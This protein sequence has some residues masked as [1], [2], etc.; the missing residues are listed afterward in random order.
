MHKTLDDLVT[1][2]FVLTGAIDA[3]KH[4]LGD[5]MDAQTVLLISKMEKSALELFDIIEEL[6]K[7]AS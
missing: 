6:R 4:R 1:P 2:L 3:I 7:K 5:K